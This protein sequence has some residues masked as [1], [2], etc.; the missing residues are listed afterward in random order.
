MPATGAPATRPLRMMARV[1]PFRISRG[2]RLM[3][4]PNKLR[5][6]VLCFLACVL[7]QQII[8]RHVLSDGLLMLLV[9]AWRL[10]RIQ[11]RALIGRI[12]NKLRGP[13]R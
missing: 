6:V 5:L 10:P 13:I 8:R 7:A 9:L 4:N 12:L 3:G 2:C 11:G 1:E